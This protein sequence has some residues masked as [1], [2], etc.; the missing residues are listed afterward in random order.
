[1][2]IFVTVLR[3]AP[4]RA[5]RFAEAEIESKKALCELL[6]MDP[7][8]DVPADGTVGFFASSDPPPVFNDERAEASVIHRA[9]R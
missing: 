5:R 8:C 4:H 7:G 9:G 6:R 1:M 2:Q 3:A